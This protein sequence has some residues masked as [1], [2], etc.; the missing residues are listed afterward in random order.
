MEH[1]ESFLFG[2]HKK[3]KGEKKVFV[4]QAQKQ[5]AWIFFFGSERKTWKIQT[6]TFFPFTIEVFQPLRSVLLTITTTKPSD[7]TSG[8]LTAYYDDIARRLLPI[9]NSFQL[10]WAQRRADALPGLLDDAASGM[11]WTSG[12]SVD[13]S[14]QEILR[15]E[16]SLSVSDSLILVDPSDVDFAISLLRQIYVT[17]NNLALQSRA[18]SDQMGV[19]LTAL[20]N[21]HQKAI[22]ELAD[23]FVAILAKQDAQ[24]HLN[25]AEVFRLATR[26]VT[27][28]EMF[29]D[30]VTRYT[31]YFRLPVETTPGVNV[32]IRLPESSVAR[33]RV[34]IEDLR[35]MTINSPPYPSRARFDQVTRELRMMAAS[36]TDVVLEARDEARRIAEGRKSSGFESIPEPAKGVR[37]GGPGAPSVKRTKD[38]VVEKFSVSA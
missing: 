37:K 38:I 17:Y 22:T 32:R 33:V 26:G 13:V 8:A 9:V 18:D 10:L 23:D 27:E 25:A 28:V 15:L 6:I 16:E 29:K 19:T 5:S 31:N 2:V 1:F 21:A 7:N 4:I 36:N 3:E 20:Y 34:L 30:V 24:G 12:A 11:Q 35:R 14:I